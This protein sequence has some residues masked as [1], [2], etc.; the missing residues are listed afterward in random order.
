MS[1]SQDNQ[2][3]ALMSVIQ[4]AMTIFIT[5]ST[6]YS[7]TVRCIFS[8]SVLVLYCSWFRTEHTTAI[9]EWLAHHVTTTT[10]CLQCSYTHT[11]M[12]GRQEEHPVR[13]GAGMVI[14]LERGTNDLHMVQLMPLPP[15]HLFTFVTFTVIFSPW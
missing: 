2:A 13:W 3:Q 5:I 14:C 15:Y 12:V 9:S 4:H 1:V 7:A 6:S 11:L 10:I 8:S